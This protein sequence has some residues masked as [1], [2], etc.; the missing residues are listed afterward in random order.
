[1][2]VTDDMIAAMAASYGAP[3]RR[4]FDLNV[5]AKEMAR[6]RSSQ[7]DGRNH[8]VT[9]YIRKDDRLIV[10]AKHIYPPDLYRAP[11]GGLKPGEDFETGINREVAEETGCLIALDKFLLQTE[12]WFHHQLDQLFWRSFVFTADYV[13][14]DFNYT[15]FHEI[16]EVR[17]ARWDE[18]EHF[19]RVMR[20]TELGGLHYRA[21]LHETIVELLNGKGSL[22]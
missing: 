1:V 4:R 7:T 6:I 19:G 14:G 15:D 12:V 10:M 16:R 5:T 13:E 8:D 18:F 17:L 9:L 20:S 11:S 21:A 3:Q 22:G 2:Y